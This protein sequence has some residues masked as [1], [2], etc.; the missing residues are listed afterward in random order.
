MKP[1]FYSD[2]VKIDSIHTSLDGLGLSVEEK[3]ELIMIVESS[4]H[5]VVLDT[6]LSHL[7]EHTK[8]TFMSHVVSKDHEKA[9]DMIQSNIAD[10][11]KKILD[12][13]DVLSKKLHEDIK[14]ARKK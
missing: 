10:A 6:V 7:P 1:H 4:V 5:H 11:E 14:E 8:K 3:T 2:I 9:W 12:A 13:V